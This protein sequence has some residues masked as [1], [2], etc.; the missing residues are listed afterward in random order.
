MHGGD[1]LS[2]FFFLPFSTTYMLAVTLRSTE[3]RPF[4]GEADGII[5]YYNMSVVMILCYSIQT[6]HTYI[7]VYIYIYI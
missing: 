1:V 7:F 4:I 3:R 6:I 2:G 5:L